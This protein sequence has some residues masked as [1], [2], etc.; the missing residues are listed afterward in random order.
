MATQQVKNILISFLCIALSNIFGNLDGAQA[1][2]VAPNCGSIF[3]SSSIAKENTKP[4]IL[5]EL[6]KQTKTN[7][8]AGLDG[9]WG[10]KLLPDSD[11]AWSDPVYLKELVSFASPQ[12]TNYSGKAADLLNR[13][14][15]LFSSLASEGSIVRI[16][17][18][19]TDANNMLFDLVKETK[20]FV[21]KYG[22]ARTPQFLYFGY[23]FG[24]S[25]G[26][27]HE[28]KLIDELQIPSPMFYPNKKLSPQELKQLIKIENQA[29]AFIQKKAN[30]RKF[31]VAGIFIEPIAMA[32]GMYMFR[33]EFVTRLRKISRELGIP[34]VA[35]EILTGGGRTGKFWAYQH[36]PDFVP[37]LVTF[38]KGLVVSGVF[39]PAQK[40]RQRLDQGVYIDTSI[41]FPTTTS[42]NPLALLQSH[43]MLLQI[44][45]RNLIQ[46]AEFVGQYLLQRLNEKLEKVKAEKLE[47]MMKNYPDQIDKTTYLN[48]FA[49]DEYQAKGVGL[50]LVT[51]SLGY[52]IFNYQSLGV[53]RDRLL[54]PLNFT[55]AD[56]DA[57]IDGQL[58]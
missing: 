2:P 36:Y 30:S 10:T 5:N 26:P 45:N 34:I 33:S 40:L 32:N 8:G 52:E 17:S 38:G 3:V 54:L 42:A 28:M 1:L 7:P 14:Q 39:K 44:K 4:I 13:Y 50:M 51:G 27:I 25:Y 16:T 49:L 6:L 46:N 47:K 15:Q 41:S 35:D 24:G 29:I 20:R 56:V 12:I 22:R 57:L 9:Q 21:N 31:S 55:L 48:H 18:N 58:N 37:D 53:L 43:Q 19:G 23:P 11:P